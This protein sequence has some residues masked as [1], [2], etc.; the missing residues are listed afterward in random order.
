MTGP[1]ELTGIQDD[2]ELLD[3]VGRG[4]ALRA[5]DD[6]IAGVLVDWRADI[7]D[8]FSGSAVPGVDARPGALMVPLPR[9][10]RRP[11]LRRSVRTAVVAAGLVGVLSSL[12]VGA[13]ASKAS[14]DSVLFPLTRVVASEHAQSVEARDD[15]W[16][17][18]QRANRQAAAG[19]LAG[20]HRALRS[21]QG[22]LADVRPEDGREVLRAQ[23]RQA[24]SQLGAAPVGAA[25]PTP[26]PQSTVAPQSPSPTPDSSSLPQPS[27]Q[28]QPTPTPS[29]APPPAEPDDPSP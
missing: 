11:V 20:A 15:V 12:G 7:V 26:A 21:A 2:D 24:Q 1:L 22:R 16:A 23:L 18:L 6:G 13:V 3:R 25:T 28:P 17:D 14:P 19:D 29:A 5:D 10:R 27:A 9:A 8:A 4:R